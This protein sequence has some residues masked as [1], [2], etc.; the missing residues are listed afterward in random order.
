M[1]RRQFLF[2]DEVIQSD[3][4]IRVAKCGIVL[5]QWFMS[6]MTDNELVIS[7]C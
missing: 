2:V 4:G 5:R 6:G 1:E 3:R 7:D